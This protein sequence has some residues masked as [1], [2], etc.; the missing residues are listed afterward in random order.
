MVGIW[1]IYGEYMVGIWCL[2]GRYMVGIWLIYGRYMVGIWL[3]YGVYMVDRTSNDS[4]WLEGRFALIYFV[5]KYHEINLAIKHQT[6]LHL[7]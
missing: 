2:Y 3:I 5:H 4:V 6:Y 1:C 7:S